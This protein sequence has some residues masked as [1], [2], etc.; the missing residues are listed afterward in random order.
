MNL[1]E[2]AFERFRFQKCTQHFNTTFEDL[3]LNVTFVQNTVNKMNQTVLTPQAQ[4]YERNLSGTI[5]GRTDNF[6]L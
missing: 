2:Y 4:S 6:D 5:I 3:N 1:H